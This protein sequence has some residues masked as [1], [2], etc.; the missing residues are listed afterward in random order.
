MRRHHG[1]ANSAVAHQ[2]IASQAEPQ[3]RHF[4]RQLADEGGQIHDVARGKEEIGRTSRMPG[5]MFGH[6][7]IVQHAAAEF[8]REFQSV[9]RAHAAAPDAKRFLRSWATAPKLPAPM[10][11]TTSPS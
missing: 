6:G 3:Q 8:R 2:Q 4:G 9:L 1:A 5:G 7:Y 11:N 10:V